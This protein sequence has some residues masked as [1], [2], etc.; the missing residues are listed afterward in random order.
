MTVQLPSTHGVRFRRKRSEIRDGHDKDAVG[1]GLVATRGRFVACRRRRLRHDGGDATQRT[2]ESCGC[3]QRVRPTRGV[4][5]SFVV[6]ALAVIVAVAASTLTRTTN[7]YY[8][9]HSSDTSRPALS[10]LDAEGRVN[11]EQQPAA[12][13]GGVRLIFSYE[14]NDIS[15][16]SRQRVNMLVPPSEPLEGL[17]GQSGFWVE[18]RDKAGHPLR[19]QLMRDPIRHDAEVFSEDPAR[20]VARIPVERPSGVFVVLIPEIAGA[21]HLV[22]IGT[23]P[24]ERPAIREAREIARFNLGE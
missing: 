12:G 7:T 11:Q 10:I 23:P 15:L 5:A 6:L 13:P 9:P 1:Y 18:V 8:D 19:R 2:N 20:S 21:E 16:V 24:A 4:L 3:S 22:L 14:G 17:A